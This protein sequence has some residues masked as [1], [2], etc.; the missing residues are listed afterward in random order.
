MNHF[1]L[2]DRRPRKRNGVQ[3]HQETATPAAAQQ[4]VAAAK[5]RPT[6]LFDALSL[7]ATRHKGTAL[8][9]VV[10]SL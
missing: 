2:H 7:A 10:Q 1:A 6:T 8:D 3:E 4:A 5:E 9:F